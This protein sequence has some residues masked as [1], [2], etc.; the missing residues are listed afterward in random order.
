MRGYKDN[1]LFK[2]IIILITSGIVV[3][4]FEIISK[5]I[6]TN[7]LGIKIMSLYS[8]L[9]PI[10][11]FV[12]TI[13]QFSFPISISKLS[14]EG[15]YDNKNLLLSAFKIGIVVDIILI[16]ITLLSANYISSL[17][18]HQDLKS[19]INCICT[20]IPFITISSIQ[21][22]FLN[23]KED[24]F[25]TSITNI[26][27]EIIKIILIIIILPIVIRYKEIVSINF[28]ILFTN[29]TE[30]TTIFILNKK[31][32]K[33]IIKN[34]KNNNKTIYKNILAISLPTTLIKLI[35]A[36]GHFLE[37]IIL[38]NFIT[39]YNTNYITLEYGIINSYV[40]SILSL[41]SFFSILMSSALL[42]NITKLYNDKKYYDFSKKIRIS[43]LVSLLFG[44][45]SITF[46]L[47]YPK[48]ILI[49]IYNTSLGINYIKV[50]APLFIF[51][52]VTPILSIILQSTGKTI[53]LFKISIITTIIR[54][55]SL[56]LFCNL[57]Y[58][59]NGLIYSI[60]I[61]IIITTTLLLLYIIKI[62][63]EEN[64]VIF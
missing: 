4:I 56:L 49:L 11:I 59:I 16:L 21:K 24:M 41:P 63:K 29:I 51:T 28:F 6:Y 50:L 2:N 54:Y 40:I 42:P 31:I 45:I 15:I 62:K 12:I 61:S 3:K 8:L 19:S 64:L 44:I 32:S 57:G 35:F 47:L 55:L 46:I 30:I 27:E 22:G 18:R 20:I 43:I 7:I 14:A 17:I 13:C 26:I 53:E 52:Y 1:I 23:G 36:T 60:A 37:P 5:V 9:I 33:Y 25:L 38:M 39:G 48:N 10:L 34:S 58:G